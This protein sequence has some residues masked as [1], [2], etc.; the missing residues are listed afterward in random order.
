M[1]EVGA[2]FFKDTGSTLIPLQPAF[3]FQDCEAG[4]GD[5]HADPVSGGQQLFC[6]P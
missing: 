4:S 1:L 6:D 3:L 2:Q 5:E